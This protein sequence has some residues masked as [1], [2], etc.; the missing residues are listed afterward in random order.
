VGHAV[1]LISNDVGR[2][3][4]LA[5]CANHLVLSP[6]QAVVATY[7]I[8]TQL[9]PSTLAGMALFL[10]TLPILVYIGHVSAA[11]ALCTHTLDIPFTNTALCTLADGNVGAD[12]RAH[13]DH[14]RGLCRHRRAEDVRL[15]G[16]LQGLCPQSPLA[17]V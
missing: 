4:Q 1:N 8:W 9:G 10:F 2:F 5:Q 11:S 7:L 13:Q 3:V 6:I 16:A 14:S 17:G 15:G 12:R